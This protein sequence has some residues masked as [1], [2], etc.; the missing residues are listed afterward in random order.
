MEIKQSIEIKPKLSQQLVMT[1]QLKMAI[2]LLQLSRLELQD[3]LNQE[4]E[5]NPVL[6]SIA[7]EAIVTEEKVEAS[8]EAV[9]D[10]LKSL[11]VLDSSDIKKGEDFP[12]KKTDDVNWYKYIENSNYDSE[13]PSYS[14]EKEDSEDQ[15]SFESITPKK[16]SLLDHLVWQIRMS[17][18]SEAEEQFC[19]LVI[20]NLNEDGYLSKDVTV[21][22]LAEEVGLE[23]DEAEEVLKEI[24]EFDP[25]GVA[26][27]DLRECLLVQAK[28]LH[29]P[30]IV[31]NILSNYLDKLE[32]KN[33]IYIARKL[34]TTIEN[35]I[36]AAKMI[37][38]LEPRP[39]RNFVGDETIYITPDLYV[40]KVGDDYIVEPND[41]GLPRLRISRYYRMAMYKDP[42][43]NEY[44]KQKL[45]NAKWLIHAIEQRRRTILKVAECIIEKQRDFFDFGP[46][47][48]RPMVLRDVA[49]SLGLHESTISRVTNNKYMH[50]PYGIFKL[51]FFFNSGINRE[52]EDQIASE[53]VKRKIKEITDKEDK[54]RPLSD[55]TIVEL[56]KKDG[57]II[58]RRTVAKYREMLGIL[59]SSKRKQLY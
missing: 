25:I 31:E 57:I 29:L 1:P 43:A 16:E 12:Y 23:E 14:Y 48:L 22:E 54:K 39:S 17:N 38:N 44:I 51:K 4:L 27:R 55:Q 50:T 24:Q 34:K 9:T 58:A 42:N 40:R 59:P 15:V 2:Q 47:Y 35:V 41:D 32:K 36:E 52:N 46:E 26:S 56:L 10:N 20:G 21:K 28:V 53:G 33:Y 5:E 3:K 13:S 30:S 37:S 18:F 7:E 49:Q 45:N 8:K 6:E 11:D 19:L